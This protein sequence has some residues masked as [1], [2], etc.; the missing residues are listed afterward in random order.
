[1]SD[2]IPTLTTTAELS[3]FCMRASQTPYLTVD[4]EFLRQHT[5][6]AK[7][8]LI[9]LA[10]PGADADSAVLVD[11]LA[12][13][14]DLAPLYDLFRDNSIP[15]VFHAARQDLEIF[16]TEAG[17][18]PAPLFD[19][20]VA[21]MVCGF[22]DQVGYETLVKRIAKQ[23]LDKSS[24]LTDWSRRPL[25][26]SQKAYALADVTHLRAVYEHLSQ[27]LDHS[28]R[29]AWVRQEMEALIDPATY[30]MRPEDAWQ[31]IRIRS[32]SGPFLAAVKELACVREKIAQ[33]KNVPKTRILKDEA[34]LELAS[35]RPTTLQ[36]L[37]RS[38]L[39]TREARK[40][41]IAN[42]ML[43]AITRAKQYGPEDLPPPRKSD[44][45]QR[46]NPAITDLLRVLLKAKSEDERVAP[47]LLAS[48]ADLSELAA[49]N[50]NVPALQGWRAEIFGN[51]ALRLCNGEVGLTAQGRKIRLME[52]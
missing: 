38:R 25:S 26:A 13:H 9:Q 4:T 24:R 30:E 50:R 18:F 23:T 48:A 33:T 47:K 15:K 43:A 29:H 35:N 6:Y 20:Q 3:A 39:L 1:M 52:I 45:R 32:G 36:E 34:L 40:E 2:N 28:N 11:P 46:A 37:N 17:I 41:E 44:D 49:G 14:I 27:Q 16:F 8:C 5:Y 21:A 22:G 42:A 51:D 12:P 19:T 31:R 7:L 10:Y